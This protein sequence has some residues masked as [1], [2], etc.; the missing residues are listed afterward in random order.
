MLAA[1]QKRG[2]AI[3]A[4][5]QVQIA[6]TAGEEGRLF[7]SIGTR[8]I[9]DALTAA[10]CETDKAEVRLPDGVIRELGDYEILIQLHAEVMTTANISVVAE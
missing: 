10:G 2:D 3:Q 7:G 1:A 9:A 6:A 5:E 4:L 8:D